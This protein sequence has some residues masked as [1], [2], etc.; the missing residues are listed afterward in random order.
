MS[1]GVVNAIDN[2]R[3]AGRVGNHASI[4]SGTADSW[5]DLHPASAV[6]SEAHCMSGD[7][8]IGYVSIE[9]APGERRDHASIWRSTAESWVDLHLLLPSNYFSSVASSVAINGSRVEVVGWA[10]NSVSNND[11]AF[12]WIG[13]LCPA[14]FDNNGAAD[15]PDIFA[16]LAAWFASDPRADFDG[17]NGIG[18]PDIFAFL[19]A[20]FAGCP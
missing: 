13:N 14:D 11:E 6:S 19:A 9:V 12:L 10:R 18:V 5:L 16:F 15:V 4:W 2:G 3:Q 8:Q 17:L 20:W 7:W 1:G